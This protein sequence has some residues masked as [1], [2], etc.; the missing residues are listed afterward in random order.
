MCKVDC[1]K[2]LAVMVVFGEA[3]RP[4]ADWNLEKC[5]LLSLPMFALM[6]APMMSFDFMGSLLRRVSSVLRKQR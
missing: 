5:R 1:E 4:R 2:A 3:V 6:L